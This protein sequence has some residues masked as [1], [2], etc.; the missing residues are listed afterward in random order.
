MAFIQGTPKNDNLTGSSFADTIYGYSGNDK[1]SGYS[2]NDTLY[3]GSGDDTLYGGSGNDRLY[4]GSG[5]DTASYRQAT[6]GIVANLKKGIVVTPIFDPSSQPK[7]MPLGDSITKGEHRVDP[8]PGTYRIQLWNNVSA[9]GLKIDFV[10]SQFNGPPSLGDKNHEGHGGWTIDEI[11][12]LVNRGILKTYQPDIVLLMI[13]TNDALGRSSLKEMYNDLSY[14]ID[15]IAQQSANTQILVSSIAPIDAS[16]RSETAA[17]LAKDFNALLP[18]LV[19]RKVAQGKNISFVN[20]GGSLKLS[21]LTADGIHPRRQGY[22][23]LG[24]AWYDALVD[25]DTLTGIENVTG[26]R[27]ADKLIGNGAANVLQGNAGNDTLIGGFG[28]DTLIGGS[29]YDRFVFNFP[30]EGV[31]VIKDFNPNFDKIA[32]SQAGFGGGLSLGTITSKEFRVAAS[33]QNSSDRFI[34][35]RNNGNLFFDVDGTGNTNAIQIAQLIGEPNITRNNIV[36][37]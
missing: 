10:G 5:N 18:G 26:S 15:R 25:R 2:G 23:K 13:G 34:Y 33:A 4:G 30:A 6:Q 16:V 17:N 27:F 20:A 22:D 32:V 3:G 29:G 35:N 11:T 37:I 7:I 19:E 14:L 1:I 9:D 28:N 24:N 36:V 21:D 8:T 12:N 31:D